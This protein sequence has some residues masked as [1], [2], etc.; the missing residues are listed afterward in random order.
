[1]EGGGEGGNSETSEE[2]AATNHMRHD[3]GWDSEGCGKTE[4]DRS[5]PDAF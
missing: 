4:G 1:M 3:S 5:T 2:D